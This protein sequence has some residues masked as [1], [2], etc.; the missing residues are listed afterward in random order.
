MCASVEVEFE[1]CGGEDDGAG[2]TAFEDGGVLECEFSL[3]KEE[4]IA[5]G[6]VYGD[7]GSSDADLCGADGVFD[8]LLVEEDASLSVEQM[9]L[10]VN[11]W[12]KVSKLCFVVPR[13]MGL[14]CGECDGAEHGSRVNVGK[15]DGFSERTAEGAFSSPCGSVDGDDGMW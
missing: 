4:E 12:E 1:G 9:K 14:L 15:S 5:D 6:G 3:L 10:E 2:V 7:S 8:I 13:D 11:G